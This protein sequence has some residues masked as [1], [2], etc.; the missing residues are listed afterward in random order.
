MIQFTPIGTVHNEMV[1]SHRDTPWTQIESEI[2]IDERWREGLDGLD[3]FSHIWVIFTFHRVSRDV[4]PRVH[5]MR[6]EWLPLVGVFASRSPSR[7]NPIGISAVQLLSVNGTTLRVRG[8]EAFD[9]TPVLDLKPYLERGDSKT[10]THA[11]EWVARYWA[12]QPPEP[13]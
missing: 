8:L 10:N 3:Q 13:Q 4:S 5:P 12:T 9:G 6:A 2:V 11:A 7:P 1:E